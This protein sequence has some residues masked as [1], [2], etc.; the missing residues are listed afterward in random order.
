MTDLSPN[1][2]EPQDRQFLS[3]SDWPALVGFLVFLFLI[4]TLLFIAAGTVR[5]LAAWLYTALYIGAALSG[6]VA[7]FF[8]HPDLLAERARFARAE[9]TEPADRAMVAVVGILGPLTIVLVA[10]LDHRLGWT[11]PI[12]GALSALGLAL[13]VLGYGLGTW[14]MAVNRFFSAVVRIQKDRGHTV[15]TDGPYQLVRH[16]AYAGAL[17]ASIGV[18]LLLG[19][20]WSLVPSLLM[21]AALMARTRVEDLT[22][23][24]ELEGY[25]EYAEQVRYRLF[26]LVW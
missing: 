8:R 25:P 1:A 23:M 12:P 2:V 19:S 22:L 17:L 13:V 16:P 7:A 5:W 6:R 4:P 9:G 21:A 26:P 20:V 11:P 24:R 3:A 18:P 10:G 14:A 15:V